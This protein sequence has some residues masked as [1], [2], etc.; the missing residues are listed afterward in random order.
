MNIMNKKE[1]ED[2]LGRFDSKKYIEENTVQVVRKMYEEGKSVGDIELC[3]LF[4]AMVSWGPKKNMIEAAYRMMDMC[5]WKPLEFICLGDFYD[6]PD[7]E[8][9]YRTV[10]GKEFKQVCH[11]LR[12]FYNKRGSV[13]NVLL[14]N[15]E[16][17]VDDI[18]IAISRWC[19]E[20]KFGSP[21]NNSACKR[22]CL[23][24]RWMIRKDSVDI[25]LWQ[26]GNVKPE[27]LYAVI[28]SVSVRAA[29][30]SGLI[31]Y[32]KESWKAVQ[33]L[34]YIYKSWDHKDPLKYDLLKF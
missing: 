29:S 25:G 15:P 7:D 21:L 31:S 24:L 5:D 28:D 27:N 16:T 10:K 13:R 33:E 1:L 6:I 30:E 22:I 32:P 11:K 26:V 12:E 9:I 14:S 18:L 23:L 20:I 34:T 3:A 4:V 19:E 17:T 2:E 8:V